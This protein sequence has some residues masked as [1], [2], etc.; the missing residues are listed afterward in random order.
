MARV[1]RE[2]ATDA[3]ADGPGAP[4]PC[5]YSHAVGGAR[6]VWFPGRAAGCGRWCRRRGRRLCFSGRPWKHHRRTIDHFYQTL[7]CRR[8]Y[9]VIGVSELADSAITLLIQPWVAVADVVSARAELY[10]A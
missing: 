5:P 8:I 3:S 6:Q 4:S 1:S 2:G 9:R 10:Q 7:P